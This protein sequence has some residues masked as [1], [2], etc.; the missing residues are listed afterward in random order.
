MS[1]GILRE[2][3]GEYLGYCDTIGPTTP[4]LV[5]LSRAAFQG[6][7]IIITKQEAGFHNILHYGGWIYSYMSGGI[8]IVCIG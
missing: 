8:L 5:T 2:G 6:R 7:L 4:T 3:S 1:L